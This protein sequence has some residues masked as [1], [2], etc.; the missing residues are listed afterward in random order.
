MVEPVE[1]HIDDPVIVDNV[2]RDGGMESV[3]E[4]DQVQEILQPFVKK[5]S[6]GINKY[7]EV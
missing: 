5:S 3:K 6:D 1:D 4:Q 2:N 7:K